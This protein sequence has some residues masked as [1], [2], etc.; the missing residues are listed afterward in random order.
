MVLSIDLDDTRKTSSFITLMTYYSL[1]SF[2]WTSV[3]KA[4][5]FAESPPLLVLYS[6][7]SRIIR[8]LASV[9]DWDQIELSF[10]GL[11]GGTPW[12]E[13]VESYDLL[14]LFLKSKSENLN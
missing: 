14:A 1:F 13:F 3:I 5:F 6:A 11:K 4:W 2:C 12:S 8:E 9:M 10:V 7:S